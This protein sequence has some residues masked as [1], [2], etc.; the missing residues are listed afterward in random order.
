MPKRA[1]GGGAKAPPGAERKGALVVPIRCIECGSAT[2]FTFPIANQSPGAVFGEQGWSVLNEPEEGNVVF[3]CG[4][5]FEKE[6]KSE[7][8]QGTSHIRGEG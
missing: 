8:E 3:S 2:T 7:E 6:V 1:S 5:C 4:P